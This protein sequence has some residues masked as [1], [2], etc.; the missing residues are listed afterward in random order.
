M[1]WS[2]QPINGRYGYRA[3][4]KK[5]SASGLQVNITGARTA[6]QLRARGG[7]IRRSWLRPICWS[8]LC[9]ADDL[10]RLFCEFAQRAGAMS[11]VLSYFTGRRHDYG[12][13]LTRTH[14]TPEPM[15]SLR[16]F[17]FS[18]AISSARNWLLPRNPWWIR[19]AFDVGFERSMRQNI[20]GQ[21]TLL[22]HIA[23]PG[24]HGGNYENEIRTSWTSLIEISSWA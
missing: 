5:R 23:R 18:L 14:I 13:V 20:S 7:P 19:Q 6:S 8:L 24:K 11:K 21:A 16:R 12:I 15:P 3:R 4:Q 17:P 2:V 10:P 1:A 9:V 22:I